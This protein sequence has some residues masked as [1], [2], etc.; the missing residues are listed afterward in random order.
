MSG[1]NPAFP[2]KAW[3]KRLL[4]SIIRAKLLKITLLPSF[5]VSLAALTKKAEQRQ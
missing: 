5:P 3:M 2:A 4:L 1:R